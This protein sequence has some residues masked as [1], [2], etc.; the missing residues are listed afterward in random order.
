[1]TAFGRAGF[2][3][4][5]L[6]LHWE[7]IAGPQVARMCQPVKLVGEILTVKALPGAALFLAHEKRELMGRINAYLG[8]AAVS[9]IK[10]LQGG[11]AVRPASPP[12]GPKPGALPPADPAR[13][14]AGPEKLAEALEKLGRRRSQD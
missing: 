12:P 6:V 5:S 10:F 2:S 3:D 8:R 7:R 11:F 14:F 13:R 1:M 9:Q 4:P